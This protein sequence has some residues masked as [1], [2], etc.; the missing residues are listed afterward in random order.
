[1]ENSRA[2]A[3]KTMDKLRLAML[4]EDISKHKEKYPESKE[5]WLN[6]LNAEKKSSNIYE[7]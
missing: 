3:I 1:M 4:L 7:L 2:K 5:E 6:W